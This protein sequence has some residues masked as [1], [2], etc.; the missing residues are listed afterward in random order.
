MRVLW[1]NFHMKT[2]EISAEKLLGIVEEKD[3][4]IAELEQ[5]IQWLMSQIHL[6]KH[7]Q[8]G[9]SS[10]NTTDNQ[11]SLFNEAE[12]NADLAV[13][14]PELTQIKT[15]YRKRTRLTTDKLPND[16]PVEVIEHEL[17]IENRFCSDCGNELHTM[18]R[19]TREELKIIPARAVILQHVRHVY[20]CRNCEGTSDHTPIIKADMPPTNG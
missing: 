18:G 7:K 11:I 8:F 9:V 3:R 12:L 17:P 16:L 15:H 5:Q 4:R 13:P 10:E 14:E 1:Y 6:A 2:Q 20:A 19:E